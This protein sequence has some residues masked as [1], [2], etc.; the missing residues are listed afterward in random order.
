MAVNFFMLAPKGLMEMLGGARY[1]SRSR[2]L[3]LRYKPFFS[4]KR[5]LK[6]VT[7]NSR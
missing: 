1:A 2:A 5:G 3:Q 4:Q 6:A 7:L